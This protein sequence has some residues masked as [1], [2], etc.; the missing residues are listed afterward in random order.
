MAHESVYEDGEEEGLFVN[1]SVKAE[2][3]HL[4]LSTFLVCEQV[5]QQGLSY[6]ILGGGRGGGGGAG[7]DKRRQ[8]LPLAGDENKCVKRLR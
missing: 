1:I 2:C 6:T 3:L 5:R 7:Q 8:M 4:L